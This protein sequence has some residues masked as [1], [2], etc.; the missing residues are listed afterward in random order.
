M[1]RKAFLTLLILLVL[2]GGA[3]LVVFWQDLAS[4]RSTSAKIGSKPFANVQASAVAKMQFTDAKGTATLQLKDGR[5]VVKERNGY[6]AN[7]PQITDLLMKLP[8]VKVVQTE[9]VGQSL[10]GRIELLEP[11]KDVKPENSGTRFELADKDGKAL[12]NM[13]L[14]KQI[15]KTE[16]SPLPIKPQTP[17]GR[18]VLVPGNETVLVLSDALR[19]AEAKPERWLDKQF[20]KAE[21][22]K[23][24]T[25]TGSAPEAQWKITRNEEYGQWKFA[26]G[27]DNLDA[28]TAVGAVNALA[29]LEFVD[30]AIDVKPDSL[31]NSRNFAAETF[32]N[33]TYTVK[34]AKKPESDDYYLAV[35]VSGEPPRERRPEKGEKPEEKERLDKQFAEDLKRLDA[36]VKREKSFAPWAYGVTAKTLEPLLKGRNQLI[37]AKTAPASAKR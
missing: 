14:G 19:N 18:Y 2:L 12:G 32:D 13:L 26:A 35:A 15:I 24:L 4:W 3:G 25:S 37:A 8:D 27:G 28:S 10:F 5:W 7:V 22:I 31:K 33:L 36:R 1:N 17:V 6:G 20:F 21:R 23:T 9:N 34:V 11:G 29:K 16:D 30:V